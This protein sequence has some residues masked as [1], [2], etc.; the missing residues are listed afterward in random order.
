MAISIVSKKV[1]WAVDLEN[2][3][4]RFARDKMHQSHVDVVH[5]LYA[6]SVAPVHETQAQ[7]FNG[8]TA[9]RPIV[10]EEAVRRSLLNHRD[11]RVTASEMPLTEE[12]RRM[13]EI[14]SIMAQDR[15][16][17][18]FEPGGPKLYPN[19]Y[20]VGILLSKS[21]PVVDLMEMVGV[22]VATILRRLEITLSYTVRELSAS[23]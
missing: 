21:E 5:Y 2:R 15:H 18:S 10:I 19:D 6:L 17:N 12:A 8:V 3:A 20:I 22:P 23:V 13:L 9:L 1:P 7:Q 14:A 11:T 4:V 16:R